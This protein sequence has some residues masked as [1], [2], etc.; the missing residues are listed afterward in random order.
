MLDNCGAEG[1]TRAPTGKPPLDPESISMLIPN[2]R[3]QQ[4]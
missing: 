4:V 2:N 3:A 1:E